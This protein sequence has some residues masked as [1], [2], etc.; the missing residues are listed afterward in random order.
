NRSL[1]AK[2][3]SIRRSSFSKIYVEKRIKDLYK[4]FQRINLSTKF[5]LFFNRFDSFEQ[6]IVTLMLSSNRQTVHYRSQEKHSRIH[7][8]PSVYLF[9]EKWNPTLLVNVYEWLSGN[10]LDEECDNGCVERV[11]EY[12]NNYDRDVF[13][14]FIY[15]DINSLKNILKYIFKNISC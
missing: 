13:K 6:S 5:L 4:I 2:E 12:L 3:N 10:K 8:R 9:V 1:E 15:D 7:V 11:V 14:V